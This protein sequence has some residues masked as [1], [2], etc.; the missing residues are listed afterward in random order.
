MRI[1]VSILCVPRYARPRRARGSL[2]RGEL[3]S[4][5]HLSRSMRAF[6]RIL[7][8]VAIAGCRGFEPFSP[9]SAEPELNL[10]IQLKMSGDPSTGPAAFGTTLDGSKWR[11]IV[12][13]E[14]RFGALGG[15]HVLALA[16]LAIASSSWCTAVGQNEHRDLFRKDV[17]TTVTFFVDCPPLMGAGTLNL[18][19]HV[20]GVSPD[21]QVRVG[22]ERMNGPVFQTS[23]LVPTDQ[24]TDVPLP[25]GLYHVGVN[26]A[27]RCSLTQAIQRAATAT[28]VRAVVRNGVSATLFAGF[29]C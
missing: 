24:P 28:S 13:G 12:A 1:P 2:R 3:F 26:Q 5:L 18:T 6:I 4:Y 10:S 9:T 7:V 16:P 17:P 14:N 19:V 23:V 22:F 29:P 20:G 11:D 15:F 25:V 8:V 21:T 27:G